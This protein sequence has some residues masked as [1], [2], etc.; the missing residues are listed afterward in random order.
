MTGRALDIGKAIGNSAGDIRVTQYVTY[1]SKDR[2]TC[3]VI[4]IR[5]VTRKLW[6]ATMGVAKGG[7]PG[8]P[9]TPN[10]I[11]L[12]LLRIKSVRT[13]HALRIRLIEL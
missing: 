7:G 11:P 5:E 9:G 1:P 3:A 8:G 13:K 2:P 10:P 12:K 4:A 6:F